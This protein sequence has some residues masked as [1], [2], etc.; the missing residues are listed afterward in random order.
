MFKDF[1]DV[2]IIKIINSS[3]F[4]FFYKRVI[5]KAFKVAAFIDPYFR[6][7]MVDDEFKIKPKIAFF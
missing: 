7:A 4:K 5:G 6:K 3:R 1:N 2:I